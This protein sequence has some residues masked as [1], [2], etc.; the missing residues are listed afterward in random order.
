VKLVGSRRAPAEPRLAGVWGPPAA[1]LSQ[2]RGHEELRCRPAGRGGSALGEQQRQASHALVEWKRTP[3][4]R[5]LRVQYTCKWSHLSVAGGT[6][7]IVTQSQ[8]TQ[9]QLGGARRTLRVCVPR[10]ETPRSFKRALSRSP[11]QVPCTRQHLVEACGGVVVEVAQQRREHAPHQRGLPPRL[12]DQQHG[13]GEHLEAADGHHHLV[14][15]E[16]PP[17]KQHPCTPLMTRA[18]WC[19]GAW[20][21]TYAAQMVSISSS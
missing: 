6:P 10:L 11:L 19:V 3:P 13:G 15:D 12:L 17:E 7:L 20:P 8:P 21:L 5:P 16:R 14:E 2:R 1:V 18:R 9:P 4:A